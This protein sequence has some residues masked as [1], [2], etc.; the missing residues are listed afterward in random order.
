[1]NFSALNSSHH[2][3]PIENCSILIGD[4]GTRAAHLHFLKNSIPCVIGR[5]V[6]RNLEE[7][8]PL[9]SSV[10]TEISRKSSI[11]HDLTPKDVLIV[12]SKTAHIRQCFG[13]QHMYISLTDTNRYISIAPA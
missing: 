13:S 8:D 10:S 12:R 7:F 3:S 11:M 2:V 6:V 5:A 9:H 1:M 4:A